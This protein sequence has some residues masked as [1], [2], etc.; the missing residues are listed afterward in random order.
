MKKLCMVAF[1]DGRTNKNSMD[2]FDRSISVLEEVHGENQKKPI[3]FGWVNATCHVRI[4]L[5]A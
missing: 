1:L 5:I 3:T 2:S 4:L